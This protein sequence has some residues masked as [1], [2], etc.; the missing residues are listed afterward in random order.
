LQE[1]SPAGDRRF[2]SSVYRGHKIFRDSFA[3]RK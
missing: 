3:E 2:A 1:M